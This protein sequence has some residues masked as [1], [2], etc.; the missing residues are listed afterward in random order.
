[1]APGR[2][3]GSPAKKATVASGEDQPGRQLLLGVV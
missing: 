1:M 3:T 2:S